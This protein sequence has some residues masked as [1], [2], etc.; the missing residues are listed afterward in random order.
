MT[1]EPQSI[2]IFVFLLKIT[3]EGPKPKKLILASVRIAQPIA[4]E[5]YKKE[6]G[7]IFGP[8]CTKMIRK[9]LQ[10]ETFADSI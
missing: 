9:L 3:F 4:I 5:P 8:I 6:R 10:P 1:P 7:K 2:R